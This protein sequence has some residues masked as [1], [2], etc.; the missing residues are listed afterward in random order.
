MADLCFIGHRLVE[1]WVNMRRVAAGGVATKKELQVTVV[2]NSYGGPG[3]RP[4]HPLL[5]PT[6]KARGDMT[7]K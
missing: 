6:T 7:L 1:S 2:A 4:G 5:D 3:P